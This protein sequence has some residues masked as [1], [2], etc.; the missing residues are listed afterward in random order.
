VA[1]FFVS[2]TSYFNKPLEAIGI[3]QRL[4]FQADVDSRIDKKIIK[5]FLNMTDWSSSGERL[6]PFL[7]LLTFVASLEGS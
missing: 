1:A 4:M 7:N 2:E 5:D 6:P 3:C